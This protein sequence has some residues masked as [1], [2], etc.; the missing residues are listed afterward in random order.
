MELT[1]GFVVSVIKTGYNK[2]D[3][4]IPLAVCVQKIILLEIKI[5]KRSELTEVG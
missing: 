3:Y 1:E 5:S 2:Y 4:G